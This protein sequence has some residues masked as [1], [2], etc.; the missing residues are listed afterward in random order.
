MAYTALA[1]MRKKNL[2]DYG[3]DVGPMEPKLFRSRDKNSLKCAALRF[4]HNRCEG[5]RFDPVITAEEER[6]HIYRGTSLK[7]GQIPYN[8]QMDVNRLCLERCLEHFIDSGSAE[9]A[10]LVYYCFF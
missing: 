7:P 2:N 1:E 9:D 10:Y 4:I 3:V 5:L 6:D 8:M